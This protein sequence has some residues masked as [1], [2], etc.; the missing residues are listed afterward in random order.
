MKVKLIA[1]D[2]QHP[3]AKG[4]DL[5]SVR[6]CLVSAAPVSAELQEELLKVMPDIQLGQ[7]YGQ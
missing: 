6:F 5:S 4:A 2:S 3:A 1:I 7:G